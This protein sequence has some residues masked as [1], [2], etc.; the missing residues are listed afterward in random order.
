MKY[1]LGISA[2]L[3]A[4]CPL[5]ST[6]GRFQTYT[7]CNGCITCPQ[8]PQGVEVGA[9]PHLP[10]IPASVTTV[11]S[12]RCLG[13][14]QQEQMVPDGHLSPGAV[15]QLVCGHHAA[16]RTADCASAMTEVIQKS[17]TYLAASIRSV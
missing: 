7:N 6:G 14:L 4:A 5:F 15:L 3:E 9:D 13:L 8:I 10:I 17:L 12:A 2:G 16:L 1:V 11:A